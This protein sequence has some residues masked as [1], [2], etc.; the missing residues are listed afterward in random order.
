MQG[1]PS[2]VT[3][4]ELR[5]RVGSER[6][7]CVLSFPTTQ[8]VWLGRDQACDVVLPAQEVS[9]RHAS[10]FVR[11]GQ[12]CVRDHSTYGTQVDGQPLTRGVRE[13]SSPAR[14]G[15]GPFAVE[16]TLRA[17]DVD[18]K[19]LRGSR[20]RALLHARAGS[21]AVAVLLLWLACALLLSR[22]EA[23]APE[24]QTTARVHNPCP[25]P[26]GQGA[27]SLP[28]AVR[29]LRAGDRVQALHAYR[30]LAAR[31]DSRAELSI[32]AELL[33]RELACQP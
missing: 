29:L 24:A 26:A 27:A 14:L 22:S 5:V 13:L 9:R 19:L 12:L 18:V 16:V 10:L 25:A 3:N 4:S 6:S 28:E 15:L 31:D 20:F 2:G 33:A 30:A 7:A 23:G 1:A 32:V 11:D 8:T 21:V 17:G